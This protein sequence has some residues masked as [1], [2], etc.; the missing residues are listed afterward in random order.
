MCDLQY[1]RGEN[2]TVTFKCQHGPKE[3]FGNKVMACA[4]DAL[5]GKQDDQT[6]MLLCM[7]S[8]KPPHLAGEEVR[9]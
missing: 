5:V 9:V 1:K 7:F 6:A 3:C 4:L 8:H 2:G